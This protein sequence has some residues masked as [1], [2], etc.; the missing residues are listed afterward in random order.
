[1]PIY[2]KKFVLFNIVCFEMVG[3][4]SNSRSIS[5][6]GSVGLSHQMSISTVQN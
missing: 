1:M 2:Q 3:V 5:N 4:A 6:L